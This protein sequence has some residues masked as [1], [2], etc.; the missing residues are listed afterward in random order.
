MS[1]KC[2]QDEDEDESIRVLSLGRFVS[3]S[4]PFLYISTTYTISVGIYAP[5]PHCQGELRAP[6]CVAISSNSLARVFELR[7]RWPEPPMGALHSGH[8]ASSVAPPH[9]NTII[10]C[11]AFE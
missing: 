7:N 11:L 10:N 6:W 8:L 4:F 3:I 1:T 5:C 2:V 9:Y